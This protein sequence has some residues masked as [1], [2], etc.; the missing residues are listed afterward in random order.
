MVSVLVE[1]LLLPSVSHFFISGL[2]TKLTTYHLYYCHVP[3]L[4]PLSR[5]LSN[6]LVTHVFYPS[7]WRTAATFFNIALTVEQSRPCL[8]AYLNRVQTRFLTD[9]PH[10]SLK[11]TVSQPFR[12]LTVFLVIS[13]KSLG[14]PEPH[15]HSCYRDPSLVPESMAPKFSSSPSVKMS[16]PR[17]L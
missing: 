8:K 10:P 9:T 11:C 16:T 2:G 4:Y 15:N 6:E 1:Y 17:G 5:T 12:G 7:T 14:K 3:I 13:L